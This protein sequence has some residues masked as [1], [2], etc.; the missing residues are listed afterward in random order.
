MW[1]VD[2]ALAYENEAKQW[3]IAN[4]PVKQ[5]LDISTQFYFNDKFKS[6]HYSIDFIFSS[7]MAYFDT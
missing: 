2:D 6:K 3:D 7:N 5:Q 1:K 4:I